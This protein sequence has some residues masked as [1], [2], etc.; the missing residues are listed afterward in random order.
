[1]VHNTLHKT[2]R[3]WRLHPRWSLCAFLLATFGLLS[4]SALAKGINE[5]EDRPLFRSSSSRP[6][7][8]EGSQFQ[9]AG[10]RLYLPQAETDAPQ[11]ETVQSGDFYEGEMLRQLADLLQPNPTIVEVGVGAGLHCFFWATE[12]RAEE[13]IAFEPLPEC[14][15]TI[16]RNITLNNL[17]KKITLYK[18]ALGSDNGTLA[19]DFSKPGSPSETRLK[20]SSVGA[21][22]QAKKLDSI[23]LDVDRIDLIE[24]TTNGLEAE[25]LAG[26]LETFK[27]YRPPFVLVEMEVDASETKRVLDKL[28]YVPEKR[29]SHKKVLYRRSI[30]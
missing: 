22:I 10:L 30:D 12:G 5:Y 24:I 19:V 11:K 15:D 25:V 27:R 8:T 20:Q 4:S 9:V 23:K 17:D 6:G 29:F 21:T 26:A 28:G 13:V 1:M 7:P 2:V 14:T 3:V 18:F 16:D